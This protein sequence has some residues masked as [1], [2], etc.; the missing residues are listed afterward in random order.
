MS[1]NSACSGEADESV[2]ETRVTDAEVG[3]ELCPGKR[4]SGHGEHVDDEAIEIAVA[5]VARTGIGRIE[6]LEVGVVGF[7]VAGDEAKTERV[8]RSGGAMLD[9]EDESILMAPDVEVGVSPSVEVTATAE[10]EAGLG[11]RRAALAGVMD[12]EDGDVELPLERAEVAE[13]RGD[14]AGVVLVDA[15]QSDE[16]IEDEQARRTTANGVPEAGLIAG[17][18]EAQDGDGD[19]V[20]GEM[21]EVDAA[22]LADASKPR[23][24][25][26]ARVLGHVEEDGPRVVDVEGAEAR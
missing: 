18:V 12:D 10:G 9:G 8:R 17:A 6:E 26:G 4:L 5:V 24:D 11:A 1:E 14:L 3:S 15:V 23:L 22:R 2:A 20:D 21:G 7:V 16:G 13:E 19:D 25:D